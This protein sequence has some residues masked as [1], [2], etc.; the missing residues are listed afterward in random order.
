M[1]FTGN[2][3]TIAVVCIDL[4]HGFWT[5]N[6][7]NDFPEFPTRTA[8][9]L[10]W[11]RV[12]KFALFHV[13]RELSPTKEDWMLFERKKNSAKTIIGTPGVEF[14]S[15]AMPRYN[16]NIIIKQ[17]LD[18]TRSNLLDYIP[19]N[20]YKEIIIIG[21]TTSMC[22]TITAISMHQLGYSVF[23]ISDCCADQL[24]RHNMALKLYNGI[25]F[26][27]FNLEGII[28]YM[29]RRCQ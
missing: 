10:S 1:S 27:V 7:K 24:H 8:K 13:K 16:E 14:L 23:L 22:V 12:N 5:S 4:Q 21:L 11:V 18:A 9:F 6:L 2:E 25:L 17:T 29:N 28:E 26:E 20:I 15:W 19:I 3:P